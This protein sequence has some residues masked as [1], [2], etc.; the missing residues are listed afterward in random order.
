MPRL[1]RFGGFTAYSEGWALYAETLGR[2]LGV[3]TDPY[4]Y[5]GYLSSELWRAIR[6]VLDT[7]IHAKGWTL[8]QAMEYARRNSPNSETNIQAEVERFA[9][10][11]G[12][13]LAYKIGQMKIT[14]LR[15]R[16][17]AALGPRFDIKAFHRQVLE[18]GALP[19]D[20]LDAKINRWIARQRG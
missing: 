17:E 7:G 15:Q 2:E 6:L 3:Y 5:Y 4:Q 8:E 9:A 20:V 10:I 13:G 14:E 11:P 12:Q 1:R 19:M 18:S 16:A